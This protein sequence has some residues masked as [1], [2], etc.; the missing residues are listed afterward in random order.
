MQLP[1]GLTVEKIL[2]RAKKAHNNTEQWRS[3]LQDVYDFFQPDS[4]LFTQEKT[5]GQKRRQRIFDSTGEEALVEGA[6][7]CQTTIT[8]I[9]REWGLLQPDESQPLEIRESPEI[10][11]QLQDITNI[12]FAHINQSNFATQ[13][14]EFYRDWL[15]GTAS[16]SVHE[17]RTPGPVLQFRA[18]KQDE[19]SFEEGAFGV[20]ENT[21]R[22]TEIENRLIED[23]YSNA[24]L[25]DN[26]R[27]EI[28]KSPQAKVKFTE[29]HI[30]HK[31]Q[32]YIIVIDNAEKHAIWV[33]PHGS[34][35]DIV[36]ARYAARAGEIRGR[37]PAM[38]VLPDTKS[39]NKMKEFSLQKAAIDLSGMYTAVDD[40]VYNPHTLTISPG[41]VVPVGSND[42]SNPTLARLD[43]SGD[44]Q[45]TMFEV[46]EIKATIRKALFNNLREPDDTVVSA[47]QFSMEMQ[48]FA[49]R[50]GGAFGRLM[51]EGLVPILNRSMQIL[52]RR[53]LVPDLRIDGQQ[54]K[55]KFT[56]PLARAQDQEDVL[57]LQE[58]M[59]QTTEMVGPEMLA[60]AYKMEEIPGHVARMK[61]VDMSL[62][63]SPGEI[64]EKAEQ[65]AAMAA[66]VVEGEQ[67]AA[68]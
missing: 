35:Q 49:R 62:V 3:H 4:G 55:V 64:K 10:L 25:T 46:Q 66:Q 14:N 32:F 37:G 52:S 15:I 27:K 8:P 53:G 65:A 31:D 30:R 28:E 39:L 58:A 56:S 12:L 38:S 42:R 19:L 50:L 68:G 40:G 11:E 59:L 51:A 24:Q 6:N 9:Y 18:M 57:V 63:R 41:V 67:V 44:L 21:Y 13:I 20:I 16:M 54:I 61:G 1:N 23:T 34:D 17:S 36:T 5:I 29:A 47:T 2:E 26:R 60:M 48:E 7:L 43:T 45:L 33:I 22:T